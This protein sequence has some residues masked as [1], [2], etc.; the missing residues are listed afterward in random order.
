M[1]STGLTIS[2]WIDDYR[3]GRR[4]L[5]ALIDI[6]SGLRPA[7]DPAWIYCAPAEVVARQIR[8]LEA[9]VAAAAGGIEA[10]PLYGVPFAVKDNIDVAGWPTTAACPEFS[11]IPTETATVVARLI[12]AGAILLGKTNLDQFATGLVGTRSPYGA[13]PNTFDPKYVSGGSSS[14]SASVLARGLVAFTLGTDTAGSGRVPAGLNNLVGLKPTRGWLSCHGVV[15]A[16]RTL[17]CV[18]VFALTVEDAQQVTQCAA[19]FDEA[20]PFSRAAPGATPTRPAGS[21]RGTTPAGQW[22]IGMPAAAEFFGDT[23]SAD[24]FA[25]VTPLLA[26]AGPIDSFD[27]TPLADTAALLY[28]GPWVAER[29]TVAADLLARKPEAIHPIVREIVSQASRYSAA[30]TFRAIYRL[31]ELKRIADRLW[32]RFDLL[33]VPTAPGH[34]TIKQERAHPIEFNTRMGYYTNFVNLLD[35]CA[36]AL[37]AGFRSDG[38]PFGITVIAPAW[39][40]GKLIEF[41]RQWQAAQPWT[42]GNTGRTLPPAPAGGAVSAL[43]PASPAPAMVRLAVV[44]AHLRGMP[45]NHQ[46]TERNAVF[47]EETR[48]SA[49]YRLYALAGTVPPKPGMIRSAGGAPII[50]ELWDVPLAQFGSFVAEI[51]PPLGIGTIELLDGRQVKSFICESWAL[52]GATE[53]TALGGWRAFVAQRKQLVQP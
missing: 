21:G 41:G 19:G 24:R 16:C 9:R 35:W 27:F 12:D 25:S 26:A 2:E 40:E 4:R 53:I 43:P 37:P 1:P 45:L 18:S 23:V 5:A 28:T 31:A 50:V 36:L 42:L 49:D 14:G 29:Y 51:P 22:R 34:F 15:P 47:V 48:S 3:A 44:G 10:F 7:D 20:D 52:A 46:L 39:Q 38:L 11:H 32:Q 17:D 33:I 30:D 6:A 13:V 8:D